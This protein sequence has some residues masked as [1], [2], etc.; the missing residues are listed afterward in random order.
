MG[1]EFDDTEFV[2]REFQAAQRRALTSGPS[3]GLLSNLAQPPSREELDSKVTEAQQKLVELKRQQEELERERAALEEARRRLT[4][5][6]TGRTE[7]QQHLT[8]GIGLLQEAEF[9]ARRDAEQMSKTLQGLRESL[10]KV[11][12]IR[13]ETWT[14][15]T[16]PAELTRAL[17]TIENARMEW[18]SA[19]LKWP[20]LSGSEAEATDAAGSAGGG[21]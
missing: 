7:I 2:D 17:T 10:T 4:E 9:V 5:F 16:Y 20:R 1:T 21:G 12:G 3:T 15:D 8:R 18:N 19:R 13:E 14:R 11:E 6:Q